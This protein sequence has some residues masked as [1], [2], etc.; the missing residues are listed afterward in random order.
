MIVLLCIVDELLN[1]FGTILG[2]LNVLVDI[3]QIW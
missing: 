3:H 1:Y 2:E